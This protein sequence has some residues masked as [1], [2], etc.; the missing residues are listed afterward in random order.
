MAKPSECGMMALLTVNVGGCQRREGG[1]RGLALSKWRG[2]HGPS[3]R[4]EARR[5]A[6][7]V[8]SQAL[9]TVQLVLAPSR[10]D[11]K[12]R[13]HSTLPEP[14]SLLCLLPG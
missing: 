10:T 7:R 6:C 13:T 4:A 14:E 12:W 2:C 8:G 5:Q 11:P 3:V 9:G 1:L